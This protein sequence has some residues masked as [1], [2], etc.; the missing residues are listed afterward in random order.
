M[1]I[2]F[3]TIELYAYRRTDRRIQRALETGPQRRDHA[4]QNCLEGS[5]PSL[6]NP[7]LDNIRA[8]SIPFTYSQPIF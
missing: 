1:K 4:L 5:T 8:T 2:I 7:E 6:Q 3:S